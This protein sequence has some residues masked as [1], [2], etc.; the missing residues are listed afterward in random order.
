[1]ETGLKD[2]VAI[3]TGASRGIGEA[4]VMAL[5]REGV[6]LVLAA[7]STEALTKVAEA[8]ERLGGQAHSVTADMS[9]RRD[10]DRLVE[11]SQGR[12]GG[13]DILVNN[14][15]VYLG[16][17]EIQSLPV[18]EWDYTL[19]VNVK[20]PWYLSKRVHPI[21]KQRGGGSVVNISST[22]G[23]YHDPGAGAYTVSKAALNMLTT[24]CAA[25]WARDNIRVNCVAPGW[26]RTA[27]AET[28]LREMAERGQ[29][30]NPLGRVAEPDEIASLVLYLA[31]DLARY[32]T[33]D[34]IPI[35]GGELLAV[36]DPTDRRS[37]SV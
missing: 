14:A 20:G 10:L 16:D 9:D 27:M 4:C 33:G 17:R 21:M 6:K 3:V 26:V 25:E 8:V 23:L 7:R 28:E 24:V 30:I 5:A 13:V 32:V 22:S 36:L 37:S 11:E 12:F 19:D 2:R 34:V 15:G 18:D 1:M 31:S 35:D 29:P